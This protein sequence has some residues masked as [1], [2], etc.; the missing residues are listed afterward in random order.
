MV[1]KWMLKLINQQISQFARNGIDQCFCVQANNLHCRCYCLTSSV[2]C[3]RGLHILHVPYLSISW[4]NVAEVPSSATGKICQ[5]DILWRWKGTILVSQLCIPLSSSPMWM[6][7]KATTMLFQLTIWLFYM[8]NYERFF[9]ENIDNL[10]PGGIC[11]TKRFVLCMVL[12][13]LIKRL[14]SCIIT[15]VNINI[16]L[17]RCDIGVTSLWC[18][19]RLHVN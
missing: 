17:I 12:V 14:I 9:E 18:R 15:Q 6:L 16:S 1:L 3:N 13:L 7:E 5:S 11:L 4:R 10:S 19:S 8:H 2:G